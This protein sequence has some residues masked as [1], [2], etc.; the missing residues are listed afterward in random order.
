MRYLVRREKNAKAA[1][2]SAGTIPARAPRRNSE[3]QPPGIDARDLGCTEQR[4]RGGQR[5]GSGA[6]GREC[7]GVGR[8]G[9]ADDG[10]E[11]IFADATAVVPEHSGRAV[12][13]RPFIGRAQ[14][15][16]EEELPVAG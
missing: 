1:E 12:S 2:R 3:L 9:R 13:R 10:R 16:E 6:A 4:E 15:E 7:G 14:E 5:D 11:A 8:G